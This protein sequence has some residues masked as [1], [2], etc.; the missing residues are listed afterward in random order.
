MLFSLSINIYIYIYMCMYTRLRYLVA[1]QGVPA[2]Q[3][4]LA[5]PPPSTNIGDWI[6]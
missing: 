3:K 2:P 1:V 4:V 5:S 6:S